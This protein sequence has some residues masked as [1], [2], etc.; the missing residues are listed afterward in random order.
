MNM[1]KVIITL[2]ILT[3]SVCMIGNIKC[4]AASGS[5]SLG[6]SSVSIKKGKSTTVKLTV[7]NCEGAFTVSSS[8]ISIATV[9]IS[10]DGWI[11]SSATITIKGK[12]KGTATITVVAADVA[13]T[14][15][16]EVTG[17][18]TI[19]VTITDTSSSNNSSGSSISNNNT[20][21]TKV[22]T[23]AT[24][25]NLGITPNDFSGFKKATTAY[26]VTVPY[27]TEKI[28]IYATATSSK[29]TVTGTGLK[30]LSVGTN[31]FKVKVTAEDKK[32]TKT[33][34]LNITRKKEADN[35]QDNEISTDATLKN[36]GITPEKY[37]F[38][39]F[40]KMTTNYDVTVPYEAKEIKIYAEVNNSKST[41]TGTG[42]KKLDIG[43][44][45]FKVKVTAEDKKTTKTY[46]LKITR[47]EEKNDEKPI[48]NESVEKPNENQITGL[49]NLEIEGLNLT[50]T[51]SNDIYQYEIVTDEDIN[52]LDIKT[53]T[54]SEDI[55]VEIIGN[56]NLQKGEN[57]ITLLVYNSKKDETTTY[58]IITNLQDKIDLTDVNNSMSSVQR[59]LLAKKVIIIG[60]LIIIVM[61][62]IVFI[63]KRNKILSKNE[64]L[65]NNDKVDL[66]DD[67]DMFERINENTENKKKKHKKSKGKRFK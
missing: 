56:E 23:D 12:K 2:L 10:N 39:G 22:S 34:T 61:L 33:Y 30:T 62:I 14:N 55:T 49:T 60:V 63:V 46:T 3:F 36:L 43:L 40:R 53:E 51:F 21:E 44:N 4:Y 67:V 7:K 29:A 31:T 38:S 52:K 5:F 50:P 1:K 27:E 59:A 45:T 41:I 16:N 26:N 54:S 66:S 9:S 64:F 47:E 11:D 13:D 35:E 48:E 42:S 57:V 19:K 25:K 24:L 28:N 37:D 32:T 8:D 65:E 6:K 17:S 15:A 20:T 18:K 58:Q